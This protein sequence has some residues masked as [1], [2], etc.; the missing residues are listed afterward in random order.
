[1]GGHKLK[2]RI[3]MATKTNQDVQCPF[4]KAGVGQGCVNK[5]GTPF[6]T[7]IHMARWYELQNRDNDNP[8]FS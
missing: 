2:W 4:C 8:A 1:M 7:G 5:D 3:P 6:K